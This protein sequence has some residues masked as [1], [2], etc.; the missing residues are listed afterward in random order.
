[1]VKVYSKLRESSYVLVALERLRKRSWPLVPTATASVD[2]L[3]CN[4]ANTGYLNERQL[5]PGE[6]WTHLTKNASVA[7]GTTFLFGIWIVM[8][9]CDNQKKNP[10]HSEHKWQILSGLVSSCC[11]R[12]P[13]SFRDCQEMV[14]KQLMQSHSFHFLLQFSI[15]L[16]CL[17][18]HRVPLVF[19]ISFLF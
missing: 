11:D 2:E 17:H 13:G 19:S 12:Y 3:R 14:P 8:L 1:M 10:L 15:I 6:C 5:L 16:D 4:K 7:V 9:C 18:T